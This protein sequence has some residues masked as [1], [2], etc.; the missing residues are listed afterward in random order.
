MNPYMQEHK[1][2]SDNELYTFVDQKNISNI[3][4]LHNNKNLV[5]FEKKI[6]D[7]DS[8][9]ESSSLNISI[10]IS[11]SIAAS[12][13]VFMSKLKAELKDSI[14]Y[15]DTD[16]LYTTIQLDN[17]YIGNELGQLKLERI[18]KNVHF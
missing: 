10:P 9:N 2:L 11:A 7:S 18:L 12:A 8:N 5:S 6:I 14:Y 4:N 17:K 15:T 1:I 3:L 13:R 16:S